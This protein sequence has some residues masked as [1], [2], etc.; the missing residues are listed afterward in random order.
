VPRRN[1]E[2]QAEYN[3]QME[4]RIAE[5]EAEREQDRIKAEER[6]AEEE[7]QQEIDK[8]MKANLLRYVD[9]KHNDNPL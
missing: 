7:R 3:M 6:K 1:A 9:I 5:I 4:Q 2:E 8:Q